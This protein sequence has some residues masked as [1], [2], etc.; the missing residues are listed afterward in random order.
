MHQA[1]P[2]AQGG[3]KDTSCADKSVVYAVS[4]TGSRNNAYAFTTD[5]AWVGQTLNYVDQGYKT[6][7]SCD[8]IVIFGTTNNGSNGYAYGLSASGT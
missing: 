1:L 4:T 5:G 7:A 6:M 2:S 3:Y 8:Q